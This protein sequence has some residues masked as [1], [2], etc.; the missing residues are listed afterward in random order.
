[1][2]GALDTPARHL[3]VV[4]DEDSVRTRVRTILEPEGWTVTEASSGTQALALLRE[5]PFPDVV[6]LDLMMPGMD[7]LAVLTELREPRGM[8]NLPVVILST[9]GSLSSRLAATLG[10]DSCI[11]KPIDPAA[12]RLTCAELARGV[13]AER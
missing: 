8:R 5:P 3:M 7:G 6:L 11:T 9:G 10:A 1:V 2:T 12:L 4:D 13:R